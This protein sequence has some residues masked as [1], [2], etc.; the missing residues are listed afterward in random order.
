[1]F[2]VE[3]ITNARDFQ[4]EYDSDGLTRVKFTQVLQTD[5]I[6]VI[7]ETK[8]DQILTSP[9]LVNRFINSDGKAALISIRAAHSSN[10][11]SLID[12]IDSIAQLHLD[13]PYYLNGIDVIVKHLNK[14]S[15]Y[16]FMVFSGTSYL[17]MFLMVWFF[18][19]NIGQLMY[20]IITS[21]LTLFFSLGIYG[22]L[23]FHLNVFTV[24]TPP[25][26][27]ILSIINTL[28]VINAYTMENSEFSASGALMPSLKKLITP[29]IFALL[30][31]SLAFL[32]LLSSQ[33]IVLQEFGIF[34]AVGACFG[35]LLPL[36][37]GGIILPYTRSSKLSS[38]SF[39]RT[40]VSSC[41]QSVVSYSRFY[42]I[43]IVTLILVSF[44]G[45]WHLKTDMYPIDY[46]PADHPV[47]QTD[48]FMSRYWGNYFPLELLIE[49]KEPGH[50]GSVDAAQ[51]I[52]S[53]DRAIQE[54][55]SVGTTFSY[56][57]LM[58]RYSE[59]TFRSGLEDMLKDPFRSRV[60]VNQF[61]KSLQADSI[62]LFNENLTWARFHLTGKSTGN[63]ELSEKLEEVKIIGKA[64]LGTDLALTL[65]GYQAL[66]I[67]A[68][69]YAFDTML[70]SLLLSFILIFFMVWLML[71]D[72]RLAMIA[73][74][75]N[76]LPILVLLGYMGIRS[77]DLD[78]ATCTV[79]A[80]FLGIAVDDT[81]HILHRY[82]NLRI[83]LMKM[84]AVKRSYEELGEVFV[85][86]SIIL[87]IGFSVLLA[88]NLKTIIYLGELALI[89]SISAFI[90]DL[91]LIPLLIKYFHK[92]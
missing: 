58:N 79:S 87:I 63:K 33:A 56:I 88:A 49:S 9:L 84:D 24:M 44:T 29:F 7:S 35:Y 55:P 20:V 92:D 71:R 27:I 75:P 8:R 68:M 69:K 16:D 1:M 90:G 72:F 42:V 91:I 65:V 23:G 45:L 83:N 18:V 15:E 61:T 70:S 78:L 11:D 32:S 2:A 34:A 4:R 52:N 10:A 41:L 66:F 62:N 22:L 48:S 3:S 50:L 86:T 59:I 82:K 67:K 5:S 60:F 31:T 85:R 36:F 21:V 38:I 30:T 46:F 64:T 76:L 74:V 19:R 89:A 26:L 28:H 80:I 40:F 43:G 6:M 12:S 14:Q 17:I 73:I 53:F 51:K 77:I 37:L 81:I 25:L 39:L 13:R 57:T 47:Q 54:D